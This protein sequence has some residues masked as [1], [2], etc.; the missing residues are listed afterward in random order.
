MVTRA[1]AVLLSLTLL[2]AACGEVSDGP[3]AD[4][5]AGTRPPGGVEGLV[6]CGGTVYDPGSLADA[7]GISTLS[8]EQRAAIDDVG[9]PLEV[10]SDDWLVVRA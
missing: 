10:G 1:A 6:D 8:A 3:S 9:E 2:L 5:A 4:G 7:P